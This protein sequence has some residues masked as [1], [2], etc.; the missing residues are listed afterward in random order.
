[1]SL[2]SVEYVCQA[3]GAHSPHWGLCVAKGLGAWRGHSWV[4][5]PDCLSCD[6]TGFE[7]GMLGY[8]CTFCKAGHAVAARQMKAGIDPW[9]HEESDA[10]KRRNADWGTP[11]QSTGRDE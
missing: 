11:D 2:Q 7:A 6:D 10:D 4:R 5:L 3:C 8:Y 1:M 9:D